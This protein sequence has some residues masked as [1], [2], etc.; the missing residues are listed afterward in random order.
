[1]YYSNYVL[2]IGTLS[3]RRQ[4][5]K[6]LKRCSQTSEKQYTAEGTRASS[7]VCSVSLWAILHEGQWIMEYRGTCLCVFLLFCVGEIFQLHSSRQTY[8]ESFF[9]SKRYKHHVRMAGL[10]SNS[11]S[12]VLFLTRESSDCCYTHVSTWICVMC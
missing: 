12:S 8:S 9:V 10:F 6:C 11:L 7:N 5:F 1:M 4:P 2:C 3:A